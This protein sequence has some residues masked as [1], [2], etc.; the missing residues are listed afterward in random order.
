MN[1]LKIFLRILLPVLILAVGVSAAV[2]LKDSREAP[3]STPPESFL[4]LV[5]TVPAQ[6]QE[7]QLAVTARGTVEPRTETRLVAEVAGRVLEVAPA[8][9]S[10]GFF[11]ADE[12]LLELDPTDS[13][14]AAARARAG[15]AAAELALAQ[16]EADA[17]IAKRDWESSGTSAAARPLVL[18][19][20]QIAKAAAEL[21]AA[22]A[23]LAKADRD[24][25]R[26]TLRAPYAG[27]VRS[28]SVDRGQYVTLGTE[29]AQVYAVD[30]AEVRLPVPNTDLARLELSLDGR[31]VHAR[32]DELAGTDG[33]DA[34]ESPRVLL[35]AD[36][37]GASRTWEG[38]IVRTEGVID[39][40]SRMVVLVARV[41]NPYG[42]PGSAESWPLLS[43]MFVEARIEGRKLSTSVVLPRSALHVG[44][45]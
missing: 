8:L 33:T 7:V 3:E 28:R 11:E 14:L 13:L 4:P 12:V 6:Q 36:F 19:V 20:P 44:G 42:R 9:A 2:L 38:R 34:L 5:R 21:E 24:V 18:R 29:V 25:E 31:G 32:G 15:L 30:W 10:G 43:G 41:E 17:E 37:A 22:R 26:C 40:R 39:P 23:A 16:E 35:T 1:R 27:R 45:P